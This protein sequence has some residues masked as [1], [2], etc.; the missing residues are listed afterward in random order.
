MKNADLNKMYDDGFD[1][2]DKSDTAKAVER[3]LRILNEI[4]KEK[5]PELERYN[6]IS[7]YCI[8]REL[9][10]EYVL[11]EIK[12]KVF[13]WFVG[14]EQKRMQN[15]ELPED[16]ADPEWVSYK[17]KISHSTDSA[18]S[19]KWRMDFMLRNLLDKYPNLN[20]KDN[21]RT[22]TH[23]QKLTIFRRDNGICQLKIKCPGK[24]LNWDSWEC[25]HKIPWSKGGHTTVENGQVSCP[26]CNAAKGGDK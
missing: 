22:F 26:D 4:F 1:F 6:V 9:Q 7:L 25:D 24:K 2:D 20:R 23:I 18:D 5:T 14:F 17:D 13:D 12:D 19:I 11:D 3:S 21:Q 8:V 10:Q 16:E 15:E